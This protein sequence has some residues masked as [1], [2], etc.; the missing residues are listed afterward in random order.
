MD[1]LKIGI[2]GGGAMGGA[3]ARGLLKSG[4]ISSNNL[5]IADRDLDKLSD[6]QGEGVKVTVDNMEAL[7]ARDLLVVAVKPWI[8]PDVISEIIGKL[9][10]NTT[11]VCFIVAGVSSSDL[12]ELFGDRA[13]QNLSIV[14]PNTAMSVSESMTFIIPVK[15][16]PELVS[17]IFKLVG[18]AKEIEERQLTGATALASCGIAYAM[19]YVRAACEGGVQLGFRASEAQEIVGQ[20]LKGVVSLLEKPGSHPET[21][22]DKVTTPGGITIKGLNTME[23]N[24]FSSA[25]IQGLLASK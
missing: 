16:R 21:E 3:L 12:L 15:G 9:D 6:L 2:V 10:I 19:R 11:E 22:I 14:M 18:K 25:V 5:I 8:V 1:S 7:K 23:E 17:R 13:P 20:T 4:E 24:G